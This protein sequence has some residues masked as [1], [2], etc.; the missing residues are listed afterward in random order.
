MQQLKMATYFEEILG[1]MLLKVENMKNN[2]QHCLNWNSMQWTIKIQNKSEHF[3][4]GT[5]EFMSALKIMKKMKDFLPSNPMKKGV[6]MPSPNQL[7]RKILL[8]HKRLKADVEKTEME[9]FLKV[10]TSK[11]NLWVFEQH[12][13][14]A[15]NDGQGA[16]EVDDAA[17]D[18][19]A[20]APEKK[21]DEPAGGKISEFIP[22]SVKGNLSNTT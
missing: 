8:K 13:Q 4:L 18:P 7:K 2:C 19:N 17:E 9:L 6:A 21:P 15:D 16:L 10:R 3:I 22:S 1:D 11:S 12:R 5:K 14:N 20:A